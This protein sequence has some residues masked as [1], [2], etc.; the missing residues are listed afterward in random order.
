LAVVVAVGVFATGAVMRHDRTSAL[1]AVGGGLCI[2]AL[3]L[4]VVAGG[5]LGL[6]EYS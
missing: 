6:R 2:A 5:A 1:V 3:G 4:V